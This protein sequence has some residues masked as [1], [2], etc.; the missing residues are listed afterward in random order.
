MGGLVPEYHSRV[1]WLEYERQDAY[2]AKGLEIK[3]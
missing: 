2:C 1:V 3:P